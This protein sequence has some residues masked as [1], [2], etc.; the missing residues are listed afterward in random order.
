MNPEK[1]SREEI[2]ARITALLLG[3]LPAEEARLLR[4]TI[5]QDAGLQKL[6]DELQSTIVLVRE[7]KKNPADEASEPSA[8]LKLSDERRQKLLAHFKTPRPKESFWIRQ[9][10][11]SSLIPVLAVVCIVVLLAAMMLPSLAAAKKKSMKISAANVAKQK[12]LEAQIQADENPPAVAPATPA[13]VTVAVT[14]EPVLASPPAPIVLPPTEC[15]TSGTGATGSLADSGSGGVYSQ[16][17]VGYVN[18]PITA[19]SVMQAT[20]TT[21]SFALQNRDGGRPATLGDNPT[22]GTMAFS[23]GGG[24]GGGGGQISGFAN[25]LVND[26]RTQMSGQKDYAHYK[27]DH[28]IDTQTR[29]EQVENQ[30]VLPKSG[31]GVSGSTQNIDSTKSFADRT[32]GETATIANGVNLTFD[33]SGADRPRAENK[34]AEVPLGQFPAGTAGSTFA[35]RRPETTISQSIVLP[36][37]AANDATDE[38]PMDGKQVERKYGPGTETAKGVSQ[39]RNTPP[40]SEAFKSSFSGK[41]TPLPGRR[42]A[43]AESFDTVAAATVEKPTAAGFDMNL[44]QRENQKIKSEVKDATVTFDTPAPSA[45]PAAPATVAGA[46][47]YYSTTNALAVSGKVQQEAGFTDQIRRKHQI[48][49]DANSLSPA[50]VMDKSALD[51]INN[52]IAGTDKDLKQQTAQ[53]ASLRAL[54][55]TNPVKLRTVLPTMYVDAELNGKLDQLREEERQ[56]ASKKVDFATDSQGVLKE[57]ARLDTLNKQIDDR[58][59]AVVAGLEAEANNTKASLAGLKDQVAAA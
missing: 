46:T 19:G 28:S 58:V 31:P 27:A 25:G 47:V 59:T 30:W 5:S 35:Q 29:I 54:Q 24:G 7:A 3:E 26:G 36:T 39:L 42:A 44:G 9:L 14:P 56:L 18:A 52:E 49:D 55:Q 21:D 17:I 1:P 45:A 11:I 50:P 57:Q 4:W 48:T 41:I 53:L 13:P 37:L 43:I 10:Q 23:G 22:A 32:G 38:S 40:A 20:P 6:H 16:H 51:R 8:P 12:A 15:T 34:P 33:D 2:E